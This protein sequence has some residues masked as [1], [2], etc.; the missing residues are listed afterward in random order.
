MGQKIRIAV[1]KSG[2]LL[3]DSLKILKECGIK[4][5][6]GRDSLK[7]QAA[8]FPMEVFYLRNSD[9][10]HYVH[11]GI[12]DIAILGENTVLESARDLD[13]VLPLGF[14]RCRLSIAVPKGTVYPGLQWLNGKKIA[15]SY[16]HSL[17]LFL[18]KNALQADIHEISGS[19]EIA[20]N[21]G[22]ADAI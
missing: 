6:E 7:V 18:E 15:T 17:R 21:I 20:P 16:P 9:I 5:E 10:P 4:I 11:D 8:N 1:Q 19:V 3:E 2:R 14:S 22:L 13:L 12:A